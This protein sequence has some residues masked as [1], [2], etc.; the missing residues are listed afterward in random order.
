MMNTVKLDWDNITASEAH[1]RASHIETM[2]EASTTLYKT[3]HGFHCVLVFK[4]D[5][6]VDDNFKLREKYW[7][8]QNRLKISKLRYQTL[9]YGED[10]LFDCKNGHWR[11]QI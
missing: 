11:K 9:G 4:G 1:R 2:E 8:D 10:I 7:D 3:L 6:S 5:V